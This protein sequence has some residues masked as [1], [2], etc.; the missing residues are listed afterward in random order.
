MIRTVTMR[1]LWRP[2]SE[3]TRETRYGNDFLLC[4][5]E[6]VDGDCNPYGIAPG[7]FQDDR[8]R[9]APSLD[10]VN[11]RVPWTSSDPDRDYGGWI[12]ARYD[13]HNDEY[14]NANVNPTHYIIWEPPPGVRGFEY[15]PNL[16]EN[17][18]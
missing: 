14:S 1:D 3:L 7:Y 10:E 11:H 8:D 17:Q 2:I 6:L 13:M 9:P 4:A 18:T 12:A 5:P 16:P 15:A